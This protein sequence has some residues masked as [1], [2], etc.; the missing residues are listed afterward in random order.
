MYSILSNVRE[1]KDRLAR[2]FEEVIN[3][4]DERDRDHPGN[5][6]KVKEFSSVFLIV[7][8]MVRGNLLPQ[9]SLDREEWFNIRRSEEHTSELQSRG[10]LVCRLLL[11]KKKKKERMTEMMNRS[12]Q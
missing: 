12:I 3:L 9:V 10:H 5:E 2:N 6:L 11:E 7:E 1:I 8:K 4:Y